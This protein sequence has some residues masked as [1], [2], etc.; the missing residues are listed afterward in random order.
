MRR[1]PL[2]LILGSRERLESGELFLIDRAGVKQP[3]GVS[4]LVRRRFSCDFTDIGISIRLGALHRGPLSLCHTSATG[5]DIEECGQ[6]RQK[7]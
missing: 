2:N 5:H 3:L 4:D 7:N 1:L 6:N